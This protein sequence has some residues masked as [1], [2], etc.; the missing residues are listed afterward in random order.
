MKAAR[1]RSPPIDE[2]K[3][4][5]SAGNTP[6]QATPVPAVLSSSLPPGTTVPA[7]TRHQSLRSP[8]PATSGG[9]PSGSRRRANSND[10]GVDGEEGLVAPSPVVKLIVEITSHHSNDLRCVRFLHVAGDEALY[11]Q[12]QGDIQQRLTL[13]SSR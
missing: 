4:S 10:E 13:N 11:R 5:Q 3:G 1:D 2:G 6:R 9:V 12:V 8:P 7:H